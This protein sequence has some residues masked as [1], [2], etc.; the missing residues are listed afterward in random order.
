MKEYEVP[1]TSSAPFSRKLNGDRKELRTLSNMLAKGEVFNYDPDEENRWL[2]DIKQKETVYKMQNATQTY[3][4]LV[5]DSNKIFHDDHPAVKFFWRALRELTPE[6]L[7][8][9][10]RSA[11]AY[12]AKAQRFKTD[13][14]RVDGT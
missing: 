14:V 8:G 6:Q 13:L 2:P 5:Y 9:L 4:G 12:V 11:A 1:W 7:E 3:N 10:V